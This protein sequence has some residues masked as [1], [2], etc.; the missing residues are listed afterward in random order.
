MSSDI[1]IY[2]N[3]SINYFNF[4]GLPKELQVD[5]LSY[6][7]S[8]DLKNFRKINRHLCHLINS[9]LI[10][11]KTINEERI[12]VTYKFIQGAC[13]QKSAICGT[14]INQFF[15]Q[16]NYYQQ[17]LFF[18]QIK[19]KTLLKDIIQRLP[20]NL[21]QLS[22]NPR[23]AKPAN[24]RNCSPLEKMVDDRILISMT[25]KFEKYSTMKTLVLSGPLSHVTDRG[26]MTLV[27]TIQSIETL[28]LVFW[29]AKLAPLDESVKA[30]MTS[31]PNL[32]NLYVSSD[33]VN[34]LGLNSIVS[35]TPNLQFL[36]IKGFN[37]WDKIQPAIVSKDKGKTIQFFKENLPNLK[38]LELSRLYLTE[39][40][41][42][43][44]FAIFEISK[45]LPNLEVVISECGGMKNNE[46]LAEIQSKKEPSLN[47]SIREEE[48]WG[49]KA[50]NEK[51]RAEA[52][53]E[54]EAKKR[55]LEATVS[56]SKTKR[57]KHT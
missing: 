9:F 10:I 30:Q 3:T 17:D 50:V 55:E 35:A 39:E 33:C 57:R 38:Y 2:S 8:Q 23:W 1:Q 29:D 26:V 16:A 42:I 46:I 27:S 7:S 11:P 24:P 47:I 13:D 49:L 56:Q 28:C 14:W 48:K 54:A 20:V 25:K 15:K 51:Q 31:L 5:V 52:K 21:A 22:I 32:K 4:Q 45:F 19:N 53:K 37:Q 6:C 34:L 12:S 36:K 40:P 41:L 18:N 44:D 43:A